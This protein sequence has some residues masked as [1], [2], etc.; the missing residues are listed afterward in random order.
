MKS[1]T[2]LFGRKNK[3]KKKNQY[4]QKNK[5]SSNVSVKNKDKHQKTKTNASV[6]KAKKKC[7]NLRA[8]ASCENPNTEMV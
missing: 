8:D 7:F 2:L 4:N 5:A 3:K 6:W 1:P